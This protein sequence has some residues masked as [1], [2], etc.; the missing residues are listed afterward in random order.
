M[1]AIKD[2]ETN[3]FILYIPNCGWTSSELGWK[4]GIGPYFSLPEALKR[5]EQKLGQT[6]WVPK[7]VDLTT[8]GIKLR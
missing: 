6:A 5:M 3:S 2:K 4:I 8:D 1:F 7:I